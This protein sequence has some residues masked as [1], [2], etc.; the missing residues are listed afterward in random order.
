MASSG[1]QS[2]EG[3]VA[4]GVVSVWV[5]NETS[6]ESVSYAAVLCRTRMCSLGRPVCHH[7]LPMSSCHVQH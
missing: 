1:L 5:C 3:F 6:R 4:Q 2:F 7:H